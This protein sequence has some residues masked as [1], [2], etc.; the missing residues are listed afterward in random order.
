MEGGLY[1]WKKQR[2][3]SAKYG[4]YS[5]LQKP[6]P[7]PPAGYS[8]S[9]DE[10]SGEW[11]L[12]DE[13]TGDLRKHVP[14]DNPPLASAVASAVPIAFA[15]AITGAADSDGAAEANA[16]AP[17]PPSPPVPEFLTHTVMPSDTLIGICLKYKVSQAQLRRFN[18]FT[19]ENFRLCK[20]LRIPTQ[21]M[22]RQGVVVQP[23]ER[24]RDVTL[25]DF[26]NAT[27]LDAI[28]AR[29]YLDDAD[30]EVA[31]ATAAWAADEQWEQSS[32]A[33]E[34]IALQQQQ[35]AKEEEQL[36]LLQQ[37]HAK[38]KRQPPPLPPQPPIGT[39]PAATGG[40]A[41]AQV[42]VRL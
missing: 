42:A 41:A 14:L 35:R 19:G 12:F 26:R 15:T 16:P 20:E 27:G 21:H 10:K 34:K 23:Q 5:N 37:Q 29:L 11:F 38:G 3:E 2:D 9:L 24:T 32:S 6:L 17:P 33:T 22:A 25:Q 7:A 18:S 8:W 39:S 30:W 31:K 1:P 28:E 36:L 13:A 40:G 4:D